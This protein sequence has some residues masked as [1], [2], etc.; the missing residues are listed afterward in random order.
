MD[1]ASRVK[2]RS[3]KVSCWLKKREQTAANRFSRPYGDDCVRISHSELP[4][5][6]PVSLAVQRNDPPVKWFSRFSS[7]DRVFSVIVQMLRFTLKCRRRPVEPTRLITLDEIDDA[8][9]IV[10]LSS[11]KLFFSY[12]RISCSYE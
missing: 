5:V 10:V 6:R 7:Y 8:L 12:P 11:Q 9:R 4:E 1:L 3:S 2:S